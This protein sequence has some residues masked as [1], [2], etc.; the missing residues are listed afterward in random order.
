MSSRPQPPPP[1]TANATAAPPPPTAAA[2]PAQPAVQQLAAVQTPPSHT[3][4]AMRRT[5]LDD[6]LSEVDL[7]AELDRFEEIYMKECMKSRPNPTAKFNYAWALIRSKERPNIKKGV[8]MMQGLLEDRYADRDCLYYMALGYY[9]L[10]DVVSSRKCLDKLLKLAPNCR[11]AIS[12]MDIVED[13][14]TKDGVIG[15][16]IVSGIAVVGG[17]L[18]AAFAGGKR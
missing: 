6:D 1:P 15:I 4:T 9:R 16:S 12:L 18:A 7:S 17:L 13:K 2:A 5:E 3:T 11:Q 14:I 8:I 10:D